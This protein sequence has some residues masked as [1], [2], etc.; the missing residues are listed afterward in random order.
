MKNANSRRPRYGEG[1]YDGSVHHIQREM[2]DREIANLAGIGLLIGL[3]A[4]MAVDV[5]MRVFGVM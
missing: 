3:G 2:T 5:M 1:R 4:T